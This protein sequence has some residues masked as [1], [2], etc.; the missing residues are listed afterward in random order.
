MTRYAERNDEIRA[1][2]QEQIAAYERHD[3]VWVD[4]CGLNKDLYRPYGRCPRQQRLYDDISGK[5]IAPRI[6]MIAAYCNGHL[7]APFRFEGYTDTDVFNLWIDTFLLPCLKPGQVVIMDNAT[8]HKS[9]T[10]RDL[11]EDAGCHLLFLPP[12]SPDLNKIEHQWAILKQGVRAN[13]NPDLSLTQKLDQ[14]LV[15]MSRC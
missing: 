15:S 3:L 10:T 7:S 2:F 12:Y 14:Q 11:I 9:S 6:S 4:E 5:R 13:P 1:D 8:F